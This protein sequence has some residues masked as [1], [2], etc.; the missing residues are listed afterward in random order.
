MQFSMSKIALAASSL[1]LLSGIA[2][3]GSMGDVLNSEKKWFVSAAPIYGRITDGSLDRNALAFVKQSNGQFTEYVPSLSSNWGVDIGVGYQ[4]GANAEDRAYFNYTFLQNT[5]SK[6]FSLAD[7]TALMT[8]SLPKILSSGFGYQFSGNPLVSASVRTQIT[9]NNFE[10]GLNR[11]LAGAWSKDLHLSRTYAIKAANINR[12]LHA[13]YGGKYDPD[14]NGF[15]TTGVNQSVD[16]K[17]NFFGIGPKAGLGARY[18][19]TDGFSI[20][21]DL[22]LALLL[23]STNSTWNENFAGVSAFNPRF[24]QPVDQATYV[25]SKRNPSTTILAL[26]LGGNIS[27]KQSFSMSNAGQVDV[28][29]GYG[30]E[31]YIPSLGTDRQGPNFSN[32]F[33]MDNIFLKF[34]YYC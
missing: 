10:L 13:N 27:L 6:I 7:S 5:G 12:K 26:V 24:G 34:S 15:N 23:G 17:F 22:S 3:A 25:G 28:E 30:G 9:L 18:F 8:P 33:A 19:V 21:G 4:F 1:S 20:G 32:S 31:S 16:Y 14:G 2:V 29:L 11:K